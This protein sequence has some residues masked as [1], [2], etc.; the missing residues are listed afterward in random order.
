MVTNASRDREAGVNTW[1]RRIRGVLGMGLIWA[2][3]GLAIG[4]LFELIDNVL[5]MAH[6]FTRQVDM[7]PQLLAILAFRRGVLFA[8][9]LGIARGHRRFEDF[10]LAQFTAWGAASGLVLGLVSM[11][12]GGGVLFLAVTTLLSAIGGASSLV[13]ARVAE[14]RGLLDAGAGAT[15]AGLPRGEARELLGRG[16]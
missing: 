13:L 6:P 7:W 14:R 11:A 3:G 9:V 4:G 5:P 10:T 15:N 2:V 16:D 8:I 12:M 1:L